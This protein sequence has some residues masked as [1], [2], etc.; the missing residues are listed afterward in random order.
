MTQPFGILPSGE[1][2]TLYTISMGSMSAAITDYGAALVR[3]FVPDST[4][5][6][7]DVVL[8]H[9]DCTGYCTLGGALGA[10]VG[11]NANRI[12][13]ATFTLNGTQITLSKNNGENSLHSGPDGYHR[14]LWQVVSHTDHALTLELHSSHGDQGFPGN[15]VIRVTY[16][17][18]REYGLHIR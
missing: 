15:A 14:R 5:R 18:D 7:A 10:T 3:L 11:R 16:Q 2:A 8:G 13:D 1:A 4:G 9:D 6:L 17:L 12:K